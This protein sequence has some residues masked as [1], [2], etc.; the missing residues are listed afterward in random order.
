MFCPYLLF[1]KWSAVKLWFKSISVWSVD[2]SLCF[3]QALIIIWHKWW[4]G[5]SFLLKKSHFLWVPS[6]D[7]EDLITFLS[8][9]HIYS[10]RAEGWVCNNPLVLQFV[11][12]KQEVGKS[13][14]YSSFQHRLGAVG[15]K[16]NSQK[17]GKPAAPTYMSTESSP[18]EAQ[19]SAVHGA[20][21]SG[22]WCRER[23]G[24]E[25]LRN[26]TGREQRKTETLRININS[27]K[28]VHE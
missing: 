16:N 23:S 10:G 13:S 5:Y 21:L 28:A 2:P 15:Q 1:S 7:T 8:Y 18:P 27:S 14:D 9:T 25:T 19:R 11:S 4:S 6:W 26:Q 20:Y 12:G 3:C 17:S 24:E 22:V